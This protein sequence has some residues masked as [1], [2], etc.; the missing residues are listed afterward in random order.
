MKTGEFL[1]TIKKKDANYILKDLLHV[2]FNILSPFLEISGSKVS[3]STDLN[4]LK[5]FSEN[6]NV[7]EC[8]KI[9]SEPISTCTIRTAGPAEKFSKFTICKVTDKS[10]AILHESE[11]SYQIQYADI[12]TELAG[13]LKAVLSEETEK[14]GDLIFPE[15]INYEKLFLLFNIIDS[16]RY[17]YYRDAITHNE[18]G[19]LKLTTAEFGNLM[20]N[21]TSGTNFIWMISNLV[22]LVPEAI[23]FYRNTD[24]NNYNFLFDNGFLLSGKDKRSGE[25]YLLLNILS[26]E[27]GSEFMNTWYKSIGI[28]K[29]FYENGKVVTI[30]SAFICTTARSNHCFIFNNYESITYKLLESNESTEFFINLV[31]TMR[32]KEIEQTAQ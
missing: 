6:N 19:I 31:K 21:T 26:I 5:T 23:K 24:I 10:I 30:P 2:Q 8:L 4:T 20:K 13:F 18:P 22:S 11:D 17:T 15:S 7:T 32:G 25:E 27:A 1:V 28:E 3:P 9:I 29:T 16:Y 14:L 12:I